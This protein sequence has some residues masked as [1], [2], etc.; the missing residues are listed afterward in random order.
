MD[1][2]MTNWVVTQTNRFKAAATGL[3]DSR[4]SHEYVG[5]Q[6]HPVHARR[7]HFTVVL[8]YEQRDRYIQMSPLYHVRNVTTPLLVLTWGDS[9][10]GCPPG[11]GTKCIT[12]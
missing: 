12:P 7:F 8:F 10:R 1:G 9:I 2:Y 11:R 4:T 3:R 5:H 6:R